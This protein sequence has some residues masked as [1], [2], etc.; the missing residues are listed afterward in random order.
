MS[1]AFDT[2]DIAILLNDLQSIGVGGSFMSWFAFYLERKRF[3]VL[4]KKEVSDVGAMST[5][6]PQ[7]RKLVPYHL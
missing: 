7:G 5:V 6:V 2:A 3:K 1:A 4:F